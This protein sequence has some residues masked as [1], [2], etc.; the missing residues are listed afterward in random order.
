MQELMT[1]MRERQVQ[2]GQELTAVVGT[3]KKI[4][5]LCFSQPDTFWYCTRLLEKIE[6]ILS[7]SQENSQTE[8]AAS[9]VAAV[10]LLNLPKVDLKKPIG[11]T[12]SVQP[13]VKAKRFAGKLSIYAMSLESSCE[14]K[15]NVCGTIFGRFDG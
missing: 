14:T 3:D 15:T 1:Q 7:E 8:Q 13:L 6:F 11:P 12:K 5:D 4:N 2:L 9:E 10:R